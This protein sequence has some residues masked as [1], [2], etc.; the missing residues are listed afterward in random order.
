MSW[1]YN[2]QDF[3][4]LTEFAGW[5][6]LRT[7]PNPVLPFFVLRSLSYNDLLF[8]YAACQ[9]PRLQLALLWLPGFFGSGSPLKCHLHLPA[10]HNGWVTSCRGV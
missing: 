1:D 8:S 6:F 4:L 9:N 2:S 10:G 5:L 3:L 7:S